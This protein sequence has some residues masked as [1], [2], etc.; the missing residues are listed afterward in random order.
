MKLLIILTILF[1]SLN[2]FAWNNEIMSSYD[3]NGFKQRSYRQNSWNRNQIDVFNNNGFKTGT[4]KFNN[5]NNLNTGGALR[6]KNS[7]TNFG[8]Y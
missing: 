5:S 1:T 2:V 8:G 6:N 4:I 7:F 3:N